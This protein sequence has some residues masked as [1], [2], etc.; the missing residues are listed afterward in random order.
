MSVT[1]QPLSMRPLGQN[2]S[3]ISAPRLSKKLSKVTASADSTGLENDGSAPTLPKHHHSVKKLQTASVVK[4]NLR[5]RTRVRGVNDGF[6]KLKQHVPDLKNKSSKVETLRGAIDYIKRLKEL[7]GE[8]ISD[9]CTPV[10]PSSELKFEDDDGK[11]L[12]SQIIF[13][14]NIII[15]IFS[16]SSS[17]VSDLQESHFSSTSPTSTSSSSAIVKT[18]R[19]DVGINPM[20]YSLPYPD[21]VMVSWPSLSPS[22]SMSSVS[23]PSLSTLTPI[24]PEKLPSMSVTAPSWWPE[25]KQGFQ[26]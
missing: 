17:N 16:D 3:Q 20:V 6:G 13:R 23:P 8:D 5:E 14:T 15:F 10:S 11:L 4:R 9:L 25:Q 24:H 12:I 22:L 19:S 1:H 2:N 26:S 21:H 18:E 7:L